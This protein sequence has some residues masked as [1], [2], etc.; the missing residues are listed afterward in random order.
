MSDDGRLKE[1][2]MDMLAQACGEWPKDRAGKINWDN[3]MVYDSTCL[4][5]YDQALDLA[6]EFGWIKKEQ[7]MR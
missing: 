7:V 1:A 2:F 6:V 3:G 4:S 5:A